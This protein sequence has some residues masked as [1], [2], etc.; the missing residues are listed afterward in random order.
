LGT[1]HSFCAKLVR[2]GTRYGVD[3]PPAVSR[4][5][6][7]A[8]V[9]VEV[10]VEG[11][12][13]FRATLIPA[14]GGRHRVFFNGK[15]RAA[16][17]LSVGDR[18]AVQVRVDRGPRE[19]PIPPDLA[20]ALREQGVLQ[21]WESMPPGKREHILHWVEAAVHETTRQ[22]RIV[23]SVEEALREHEQRIDRRM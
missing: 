1:R 2:V 15:V 11:G 9:P 23:R 18:A 17:G 12:A 8:R 14:G 16:A 13:P 7:R 10:R 5:V 21:A 3:V 22:K 20:D 19:V 6:G 4:V